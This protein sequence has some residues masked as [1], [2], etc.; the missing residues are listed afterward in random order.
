MTS[1]QVV[2]VRDVLFY[3]RPPPPHLQCEFC[4]EEVKE[5]AVGG[6]DPPAQVVVESIQKS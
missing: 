1:T 3:R 4:K 2:L 5:A 6:F